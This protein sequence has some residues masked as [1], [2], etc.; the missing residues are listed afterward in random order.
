MEDGGSGALVQD[1][2]AFDGLIGTIVAK[3]FRLVKRIGS[4][5]M[6]RVYQAEQL[7]LGKMVA[8][9]ILRH[10]LMADEKLVRRFEQ[11]ARTASAVSHPNLI[12][13]FDCG[14][15]DALDLAYIAMELLPGPDLALVIAREAP[16]PLPRC[17]RVIDQVLAALEEA[18][19]KG[20]VHRD[21][22]PGNIM[23][24]PRRDDPDFVKVCDFGIAKIKNG[25]GRPRPSLT[26]AGLVFGTPEYMSPEQACG[27]E[28]DARTDLYS[29][30][31]IL[32]QM[33][34]GHLPFPAPSA[35]EVLAR[36]LRDEPE[37]PSQRAFTVIPDAIEDLILRAMSKDREKRPQNAAEFRIA[38]REAWAGY[39]EWPGQSTGLTTIS[40]RG[41]ASTPPP[42]APKTPVP[43][44]ERPTPRAMPLVSGATP[45][46]PSATPPGP[47]PSQAPP[48]SQGGGKPRRPKRAAIL[49]FT[50]TIACGGIALLIMSVTRGPAPESPAPQ[51]ESQEVAAMPAGGGIIVVPTAPPARGSASAESRR[52]GPPR[53]SAVRHDPRAT[54][55]LSS[56][57]KNSRHLYDPRD[58]GEPAAVGEPAIASRTPGAA[59]DS[60]PRL[61]PPAVTQPPPPGPA[62][63]G[64]RIDSA[65]KSSQGIAHKLRATS[66]PSEAE[67]LLDGKSIGR[68]PLF[69]AEVDVSQ[70]HTLT[71]RKEGYAPFE[72]TV[73]ASSPWVVRT[74][75]NVAALRVAPVLQKQKVVVAAMPSAQFQPKAAPAAAA[76]G[77][78]SPSVLAATSHKLR[79]TSIPSDAQVSIDGKVVGRT[80][81]FGAEVDTSAPH[82]LAIRKDGYALYEQTISAS[83]EWSIKPSDPTSALLRVSALLK[84]GD[85]T[86]AGA[87]P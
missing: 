35:T 83:S 34:T 22:K 84:P 63:T 15:D 30:G 65:G 80:P 87:T 68:T 47:T 71:I 39:L 78:P 61:Q 27:G 72:Q 77:A 73:T 60:D 43:R 23:L 4:G 44:S 69:G 14:R 38:M 54:A 1:S 42:G 5:A 50:V 13:T 79:I 18:H 48:G 82:R 40:M 59:A 81:L 74:S 20:I 67:V 49:G 62:A 51:P 37:R 33:V 12:E 64:G 32:Y 9:K 85:P 58:Y 56:R 41:P 29:V 17:A 10:E 19:A 86:L 52:N 28:I 46:P 24:V 21:L 36:I 3:N 55:R 16:L 70:P 57:T 31:A 75:D 25:N 66:I 2:S 11:E 6:G 7:S 53:V 26:M 45:T 76:A 8:I